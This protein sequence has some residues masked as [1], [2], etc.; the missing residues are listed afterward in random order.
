MNIDIFKVNKLGANI[1]NIVNPVIKSNLK[2]ISTN[3]ESVYVHK[4]LHLIID[5]AGNKTCYQIIPKETKYI[6]NNFLGHTYQVKNL[7]VLSFPFIDKY[8]NQYER[9]I[10]KYVYNNIEFM[11][12]NENEISYFKIKDDT[13][14]VVILKLLE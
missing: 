2:K 8:D 4:N 5:D 13:D 14:I 11:I 3:K 10:N 6:N 12:I 7:P 9:I 1:Y